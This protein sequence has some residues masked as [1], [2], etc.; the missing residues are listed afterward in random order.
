MLCLPAQQ[1]PGKC[2]KFVFK[3]KPCTHQCCHWTHLSIMSHLG[4]FSTVLNI[5]QFMRQCPVAHFDNNES[6]VIWDNSANIHVCNNKSMLIGE[7][8]HLKEHVVAMFGSSTNQAQDWD[9]YM[10]MPRQFRSWSYSSC[11]Q[12][13]LFLLF[14]HQYS[15]CHQIRPTTSRQFWNWHHHHLPWI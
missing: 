15:K 12:H 6:S 7:I 14:S 1:F 4:A 8:R 13:S 9:S 5:N 2:Y 11:E 3:R 10:V